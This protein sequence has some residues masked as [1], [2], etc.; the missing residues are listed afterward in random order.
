MWKRRRERLHRRG[1]GRRRHDGSRV[2]R[3]LVHEVLREQV[4]AEYPDQL[5]E[6]RRLDGQHAL[7]CGELDPLGGDQLHGPLRLAD[8]E[9]PLVDGD[10]AIA[11][12]RRRVLRQA[13]LERT[14]AA[15]RQGFRHEIQRGG[16]R[17]RRPS[18]TRGG[19]D[20]E[21]LA[22]DTRRLLLHLAPRGLHGD[23][24]R[25]IEQV[26]EVVLGD[27]QDPV[28]GLERDRRPSGTG[29]GHDGPGAGG[30]TQIG[31]GRRKQVLLYG[32]AEQAVPLAGAGEALLVGEE[33]EQLPGS[34]F[35]VPHGDRLEGRDE[36]IG[37]E[38]VQLLGQGRIGLRRGGPDPAQ[39]REG[40]QQ[41]ARV[42]VGTGLLVLGTVEALKS[43]PDQRARRL[44]VR[45]RV[46]R[47]RARRIPGRPPT[48]QR[49]L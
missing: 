22:R 5:G 42:L 49:T 8:D 12:L 19:E 21:V 26:V 47:R 40:Q 11:A 24:L 16:E 9:A 43:L 28:A 32:G 29:A 20:L 34:Q 27:A 38:S 48:F 6:H 17:D 1:A 13:V 46:R 4:V 33:A 7:Q 30:D 23:P 45:R 41:P 39:D 35:V 18:G 15:V 25:R 44:R 14:S 36:R 31:H 10:H 3:D 37:T 2:A